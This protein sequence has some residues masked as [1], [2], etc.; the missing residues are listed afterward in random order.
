MSARV[1]S[2]PGFCRTT[3]T[4]RITGC[5]VTCGASPMRTRSTWSSWGAA[6]AVRSW[7]SGWAGGGCGGWR[8]APGVAGG[9]WGVGALD[10]GPFWDP[11]TDWV[12]DEAGSHHLYWTDP[13]VIAG[14]DP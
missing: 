12:C 1:T 13:R 10:A 9:G 11:D 5:S 7:R 14:T 8:G 4:G 6:R 2:R 3:A